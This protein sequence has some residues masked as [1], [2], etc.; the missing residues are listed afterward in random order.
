MS[1]VLCKP[2]QE[3]KPLAKLAQ[4]SDELEKDIQMALS[5][6]V[7][8]GGQDVLLQVGRVLHAGVMVA[9]VYTCM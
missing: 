2:N 9:H 7:A 5:K 4:A 1:S 6:Y 8:N 3:G